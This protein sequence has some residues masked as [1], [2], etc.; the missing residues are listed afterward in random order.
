MHFVTEVKRSKGVKQKGQAHEHIRRVR[1]LTG[2][3]QHLPQ[4]RLIHAPNFNRRKNWRQVQ[5]LEFDVNG[6]KTRAHEP[7]NPL[8][9]PMPTAG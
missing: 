6:A 7:E 3:M 4:A 1:I 5:R 9:S 2:F 8:H